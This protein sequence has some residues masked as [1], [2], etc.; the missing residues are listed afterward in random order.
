MLSARSGCDA[1]GLQL[2]TPLRACCVFSAGSLVSSAERSPRLA[3]PV[4]MAPGG[5]PEHGSQLLVSRA[6]GIVGDSEC[7]YGSVLIAWHVMCD[8]HTAG[9]T[10]CQSR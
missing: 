2:A 7:V 4:V 9:R 6:A 1:C 3:G 10:V 5:S 8:V